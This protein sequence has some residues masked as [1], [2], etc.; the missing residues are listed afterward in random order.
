M[1]ACWYASELEKRIW[2]EVEA[3]AIRSEPVPAGLSLGVG[4]VIN[5]GEAPPMAG[6]DRIDQ[7][8][9]SRRR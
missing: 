5:S 3:P 2:L 9:A 6:M 4:E 7:P 1:A 8:V